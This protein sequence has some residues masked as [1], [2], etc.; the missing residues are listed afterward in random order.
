[1]RNAELAAEYLP[2]ALRV[3]RSFYAEHRNAAALD[4]LEGAAV[5]G[6]VS[7]AQSFDS[8]RHVP[9]WGFAHR[10]A[11]GAMKDMVRDRTHH[12]RRMHFEARSF[13]ERYDGLVQDQPA[14]YSLLHL[15][16]ATLPADQKLVLDCEFRLK[17][18]KTAIAQRCG[19][20]EFTVFHLRRKALDTLKTQLEARGIRKVS[21]V[22]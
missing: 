10:R 2:A 13:D 11:W 4:D 9:F 12:K 16:L 14:T 18:F 15:L 17:M 20:S 3:A 19:C 22:L 5:D 6:L 21:D 1:M 8:E 7:A